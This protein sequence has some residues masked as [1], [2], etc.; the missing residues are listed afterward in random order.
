MNRPLSYIAV[1]CHLLCPLRLSAFFEPFSFFR[2]WT[3][4][5]RV[6]GIVSNSRTGISVVVVV[7]A[8]AAPAVGVNS[9]GVRD[10]RS[11]LG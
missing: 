3:R 6:V 8:P 5:D 7:V 1:P 2:L 10:N 11:S 4:I 9:V